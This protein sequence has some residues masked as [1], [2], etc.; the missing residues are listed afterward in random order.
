MSRRSTRDVLP[1]PALSSSNV[2]GQPAAGEMTGRRRSSP[3][4][5]PSWSTSEPQLAVPQ[6]PRRLRAKKSAAAIVRRATTFLR[7]PPKNSVSEA[8]ALSTPKASRSRAAFQEEPFAPEVLAK[9]VQDSRY[10]SPSSLVLP[11]DDVSFSASSFFRRVDAIQ[12]SGNALA[13]AWTPSPPQAVAWIPPVSYANASRQRTAYDVS[14]SVPRPVVAVAVAA[15]AVRDSSPPIPSTG[16]KLD[17]LAEL[18]AASEELTE[19]RRIDS[20]PP[21]PRP[22]PARVHWGSSDFSDTPPTISASRASMSLKNFDSLAE[23]QAV[24]AE[25]DELSLLDSPPPVPFT[26]PRDPLAQLMAVAQELSAM[27]NLDSEDLVASPPM[28]IPPSLLSFLEVARLV[29]TPLA[30]K[31]PRISRRILEM[32]VF[33]RSFEGVDVPSIVVTQPEEPARAF[34]FSQSLPAPASTGLLAPPPTNSRGR[35]DAVFP[36]AYTPAITFLPCDEID[37]EEE[38]AM[39]PQ[40][41]GYSQFVEGFV[42]CDCA[43]CVRACEPDIPWDPSSLLEESEPVPSSPPPLL[44]SPS[45]PPIELSAPP[46][47]RRK[48]SLLQ[49]MLKRDSQPSKV[50]SPPQPPSQPTLARKRSFL[51]ISL[52]SKPSR[53]GSVKRVEKA[54][55]GLPRP[56]SPTLFPA[57][58]LVPPLGPSWEHRS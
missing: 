57:V 30:S 32:E 50:Q 10:G 35:V 17:S 37:G 16:R 41:I 54:M 20:P 52:N 1:N 6:T 42:R 55:I 5:N 4:M 31:S 39:S 28:P 26:P 12:K 36:S 2:A 49:R 25:L 24:S 9:A 21:M 34:S 38:D 47:P 19:L 18:L 14:A 46:P 58:S 33:D 3:I 13:V 53:A 40:D 8:R 23:L 22:P 48:R 56:L 43:H 11:R 7:S 27:A 15:P 51:G 29:E 45:G 44:L